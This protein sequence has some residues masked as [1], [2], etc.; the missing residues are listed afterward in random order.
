[1]LFQTMQNMIVFLFRERDE[2]LVSVYRQSVGSL[3]DEKLHAL[4]FHIVTHDAAEVRLQM[5]LHAADDERQYIVCHVDGRGIGGEHFQGGGK[6]IVQFFLIGQAGFQFILRLEQIFDVV[7]NPECRVAPENLFVLEKRHFHGT[8]PAARGHLEFL[9]LAGS[10]DFFPCMTECLVRVF[11]KFV[12]RKPYEAAVLA[13]LAHVN[14]MRDAVAAADDDAA[15]YL[16]EHGAEKFQQTAPVVVP[17]GDVAEQ[18]Q[19]QHNGERYGDQR[20]GIFRRN[21]DWLS[22]PI[23]RI[24][25]LVL[26]LTPNLWKLLAVMILFASTV[27]QLS[28]AEY[29]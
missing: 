22:M 28:F 15:R 7:R 4:F 26:R 25:A 11:R 14:E 27:S 29:S 13:E 18:S 16:L 21:I 1:M 10:E 2:I 9:R 23:I 5:L 8:V 12:H 17:Y 3:A 6:K 19:N 20:A 24:S